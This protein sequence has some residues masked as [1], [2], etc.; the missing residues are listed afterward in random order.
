MEDL[1][2]YEPVEIRV[3]GPRIGFAEDQLILDPDLSHGAVHLYVCMTMHMGSAGNG[4]IPP[5]PQLAE[6]IGE[7]LD[8]TCRYEDELFQ[9]GYVLRAEA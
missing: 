1:T 6:E 4:T 9:A 5:I 2:A 8:T 7:S 3:Q